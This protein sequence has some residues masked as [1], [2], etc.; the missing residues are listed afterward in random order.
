[1]YRSTLDIVFFIWILNLSQIQHHKY[2][3]N[4]MKKSHLKAKSQHDEILLFEKKNEQTGRQT[5]RDRIVL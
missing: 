5:L 4:Q 3:F 1:M 2:D